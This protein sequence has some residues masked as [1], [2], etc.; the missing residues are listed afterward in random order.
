MRETEPFRNRC[1]GRLTPR[2]A[3]G[4]VAPDPGPVGT[5]ASGATGPVPSERR[6]RRDRGPPV[7]AHY[8]DRS[9][10]LQLAP[11]VHAAHRRWVVQTS[12]LTCTAVT[13]RL[14]LAVLTAA[15]VGP[16]GVPEQVALTRAHLLV[17]FLSR[18]P[19]LLVAEWYPTPGARFRAP[20]RGTSSP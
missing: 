20:R 3:S 7:A 4:P 15:Q 16:A 5:G 9:A 2:A 17:P 14:R 1:L 11:L 19:D 6:S 13:L 12:A 18:V 10:G 8:A